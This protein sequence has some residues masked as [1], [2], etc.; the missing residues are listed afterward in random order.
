MIDRVSS[1]KS[2][3][4]NNKFFSNSSLLSSLKVLYYKFLSY[5]YTISGNS[6]DLAMVN[7]TWTKNHIQKLWNSLKESAEKKKLS[8]VYPPCNTKNLSAV[9]NKTGYEGIF[10]STLL[11]TKL[12]GKDFM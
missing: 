2:S 12:D 5:F 7:S 10:L 4:N 3:Y 9:M 6:L 11:K 1:L 8:L